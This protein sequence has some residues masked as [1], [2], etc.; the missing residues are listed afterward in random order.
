MLSKLASYKAVIPIIIIAILAIIIISPFFS[1]KP[2]NV[3]NQNIVPTQ[4]PDESGVSVPKVE[5]KV[6]DGLTLTNKPA[7]SETE[8]T[9]AKKQALLKVVPYY[10]KEY[11]VEYLESDDTFLITINESPLKDN[12][13]NAVKWLRDQ[14]LVETDLETL[15]IQFTHPNFVN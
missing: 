14:G 4:I 12:M 9:A 13:E 1:R 5:Y 15:K 6:G 8:Q 2:A 11:S 7:R 3:G 10:Q